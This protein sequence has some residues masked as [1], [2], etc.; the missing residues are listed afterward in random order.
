MRKGLGRRGRRQRKKQKERIPQLVGGSAR[1]GGR[2]LL[3]RK[4]SR[5]L[6]TQRAA[7]LLRQKPKRR[8]RASSCPRICALVFTHSPGGG[9]DSD[10]RRVSRFFSNFRK[11]KAEALDRS[12][13]VSCSA[14]VVGERKEFLAHGVPVPRR[15]ASC[16]SATRSA[17]PDHGPS[18]VSGFH[19][20]LR[21]L[22]GAF[23]MSLFEE[24]R[25]VES[26]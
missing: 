7:S 24:A 11:E 10:I 6:L 12:I 18:G 21:T 5:L 8:G 20:G 16:L 2:D 13:A 3:F 23:R 15:C 19:P 9:R 22:V 26:G 4:V 14:R 17:S 25:G 1:Q